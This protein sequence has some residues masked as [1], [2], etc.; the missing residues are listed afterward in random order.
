MPGVTKFN[1]QNMCLVTFISFHYGN[2]LLFILFSIL[3][4]MHEPYTH[5][6]TSKQ[7]SRSRCDY[8]QVI[9]LSLWTNV[10]ECASAGDHGD[11]ECCLLSLQTL[12]R[13]RLLSNCCA[14]LLLSGCLYATM[15]CCQAVFERDHCSY[16]GVKEGQDAVCFTYQT[17][18]SVRY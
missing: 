17:H 12:T 8:L 13:M 5:L 2:V 9:K 16:S 1:Y 14:A 4:Q 18:C 7:T 6:K 10:H 15:R 11:E 3:H